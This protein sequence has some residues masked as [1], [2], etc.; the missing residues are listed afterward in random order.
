M[1]NQMNTVEVRH[2][3]EKDEKISIWFIGVFP[4]N[5]LLH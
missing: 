2:F 4:S 1:I 5:N 3:V